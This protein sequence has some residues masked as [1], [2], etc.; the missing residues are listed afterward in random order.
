MYELL[1]YLFVA[2]FESSVTLK[3]RIVKYIS[4]KPNLII[5]SHEV[6]IIFQCFLIDFN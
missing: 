6:Y 2:I 3:M 5:S 4:Y 1:W